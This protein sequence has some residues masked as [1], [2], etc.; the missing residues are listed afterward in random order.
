MTDIYRV[1]NSIL[2]FN[3][4]IHQQKLQLSPHLKRNKSAVV[5][6]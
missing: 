4:V 1:S 6:E 2:Q 5:E 3:I